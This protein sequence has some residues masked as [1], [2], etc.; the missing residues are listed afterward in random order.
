[1]ENK[2][3]YT[4]AAFYITGKKTVSPM[5]F[6][7]YRINDDVRDSLHYCQAKASLITGYNCRIEIKLFDEKP[8]DTIEI[9]KTFSPP[10]RFMSQNEGD[11]NFDSLIFLI[12]SVNLYIR[13]MRTYEISLNVPEYLDFQ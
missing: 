5:D 4:Y 13:K 3:Q 10:K 11:I 12:R 9:C 6:F 2:Q 7:Y 8:Q 1:M